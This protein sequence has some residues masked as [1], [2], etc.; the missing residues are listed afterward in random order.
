MLGRRA[1]VV[2]LTY[3][4]RFT[5]TVTT[6]GRRVLDILNDRTTDYLH[7]HD[8][9]V[10]RSFAPETRVASFPDAVV[11][12]EDLS[13]VLI[14]GERHEAPEKR[15][16]AFVPKKPHHVFITVP[17]Y[18]VQ[19]RMLLTGAAEPVSIL[20]RETGEFFPVT[21]ATVSDVGAAGAPIEA[22]VVLINK[23]TVALF[24]VGEEPAAT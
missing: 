17:G 9:Q 10:F 15:L 19:G 2:L 4:H 18:E 3:E 12:K 24:Y 13:L 14:T 20:A 8:V 1:S 16:Y 23:A 21:Q 22:P 7:I 6:G 11:R 5:A